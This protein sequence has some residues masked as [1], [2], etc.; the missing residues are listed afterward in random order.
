M[1]TSAPA[2]DSRWPAA[3]APHRWPQNLRSRRWQDGAGRGGAGR[4]C[5]PLRPPT[6]V[7]AHTSNAPAASANVGVGGHTQER[8]PREVLPRYF[9]PLQ[10][11]KPGPCLPWLTDKL[12]VV[13]ARASAFHTRVFA[14]GVVGPAGARWTPSAGLF[15]PGCCLAKNVQGLAVKVA[16]VRGCGNVTVCALVTAGVRHVGPAVASCRWRRR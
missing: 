10:H 8:C 6:N 12:H 4:K 5:G 13:N 15:L 1:P 14:T 7:K 9:P 2:Q 16:P 3:P 11:H